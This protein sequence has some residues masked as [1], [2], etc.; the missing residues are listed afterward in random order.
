VALRKQ[1]GEEGFDAGPL[2]I[3]YHLRFFDFVQTLLLEQDSA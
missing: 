2:T 1:L 3:Q